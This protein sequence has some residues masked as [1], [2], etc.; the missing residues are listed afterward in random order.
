M[1][2]TWLLICT[3]TAGVI[4]LIDP[5]PAVGFLALANKYSDALAAGEVLAP[6]KDIDQMQNV[7]FNAYTNATLTALF[8]FVVLSVLFYAIK[9]GRNAWMKPERTDKEAPFQPIPDA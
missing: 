5:N 8:L 9:V 1:P 6:A 7:I 3:T 2:A 4:K